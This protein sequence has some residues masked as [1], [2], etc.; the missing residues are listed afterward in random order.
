MSAYLLDKENNFLEFNSDIDI[1]IA[2]FI[3]CLQTIKGEQS[4]NQNNGLDFLGIING[5]V[6]PEIEIN[7]IAE[8]YRAYFKVVVKRTE[9]IGKQLHIFLSLTLNNGDTT[10]FELNA[11]GINGNN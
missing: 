3:Q 5:R 2:D 9:I 7:N 6:L 11:G 4:F 1:K 8:R 10:E